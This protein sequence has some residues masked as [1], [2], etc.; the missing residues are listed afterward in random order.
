MVKTYS[1]VGFTDGVLSNIEGVYLDRDIAEEEL[2]KLEEKRE[3]TDT[4][5]WDIVVTD[6][7]EEEIE[8]N[9]LKV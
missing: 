8:N 4:F 1:V 5:Y 9:N 7:T 2:D 3:S 6:V